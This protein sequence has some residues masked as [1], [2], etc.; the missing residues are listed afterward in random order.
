MVIVMHSDKRVNLIPIKQRFVG[1]ETIF[2]CH[3]K[4]ATIA[5]RA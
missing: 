5:T 1:G 2:G 3:G 4:V